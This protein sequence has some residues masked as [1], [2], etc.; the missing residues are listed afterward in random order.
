M[1]S[2][3]TTTVGMTVTSPAAGVCA[4]PVVLGAMAPTGVAVRTTGL[5][6][7]GTAVR[8][9][10]SETG[11]AEFDATGVLP[12][13]NGMARQIDAD[14]LPGGYA[15]HDSTTPGDLPPGVLLS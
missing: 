5:P 9:R 8:L 7:A 14:R 11:W 15:Q 13:L 12:L 1:T 3:D 4:A 6:F 2:T 10:G